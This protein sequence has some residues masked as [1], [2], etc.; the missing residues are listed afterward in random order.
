MSYPP[1][2]D[3]AARLYSE[4]AESLKG[5]GH[6]IT[7]VTG[8][9]DEGDMVDEGLKGSYAASCRNSCDGVAVLRVSALSFLSKIPGGKALRFFLSCLLFAIRGLRARRPDVI[10]VY[11]PPLYMGISAY[12]ISKLKRTRFVFNM[13]DIHPKV[14]FD[15]GA[16]KNKWIKKVLSRM[17]DICCEKASSFI[18]YSSGNRDYLRQRG[19]A[20]EVSII[21][22]WV[23]T[24]AM[25]PPEG[26]DTFRKENLTAD[27]F[28]VSYAGTMQS[29]Q[30]LE[31]VVESA[32]TLQEYSDILFLLAGKGSSKSALQSLIN[33][34]KINNVRMLPVLPKERYVLF[35]H[36]SDVCLVTLSSAIP[37]QTVP[38]KLADIMACGKPVIAA[39]NSQGDTASIIRQA[40]CGFCVEPGDVTA[41]S[42]A[43]LRL[44]RDREL[45]KKMGEKARLFA[46]QHYARAICVTQYE[47]ALFLASRDDSSQSQ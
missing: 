2:I 31:V 1:T 36:A 46:E 43:V 7:V 34:R 26:K 30:G 28:V 45:V 20:R 37:S 40:E 5:M 25:S 38:G 18:V 16:I 24:S 15:S 13:Q 41:F 6:H 14:L 3:S 10:L 21:P 11:S 22:N 12:I 35:L 39:V 4:L 17:E 27:K 47:K 19:V 42:H 9:P 8:Y 33:E 23:D 44:Y 29:A 32:A